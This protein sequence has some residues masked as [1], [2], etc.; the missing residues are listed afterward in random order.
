MNYPTLPKSATRRGIIT[1][2]VA[3]LFGGL[4]PTPRPTGKTL[5]VRISAAGM[6][7]DYERLMREID[8]SNELC[9]RVGVEIRAEMAHTEALIAKMK[10][11]RAETPV[12]CT[13]TLSG[14]CR[15]LAMAR[16]GYAA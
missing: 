11:A 15:S 7:A 5:N 1:G 4:R 12:T 8:R 6:A 3:A 9:R 14:S 2:A 16:G 13:E 10:A